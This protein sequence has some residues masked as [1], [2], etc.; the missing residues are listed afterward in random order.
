MVREHPVSLFGRVR[1]DI[2]LHRSSIRKKLPRLAP[3][4]RVVV[5]L[6]VEVS[7]EIG[8]FSILH[9]LVHSSHLSV[10]MISCRFLE[11]KH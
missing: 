11:Q 5:L 4:S 7:L 6:V 2:D 10:T 9:V 3:N 1:S 8:V